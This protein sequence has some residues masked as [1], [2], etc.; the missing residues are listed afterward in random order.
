MAIAYLALGSN[1]NDRMAFLAQAESMINSHGGVS[2]VK[3]SSVYETEPWPKENHDGD[4]PHDEKGQTWYLNQ[5][6]Q[7]ETTLSPQELVKAAGDIE[8]QIGRTQSHKWG[9]REIDVDVLLYED[10]I[11]D[12]PEIEIPH[13][14]MRD[15]QFV[16]VPLVEIAPDLK[17][18]V[19]KNTF[20]HILD[21]VK[22]IDDHKI[23]PFL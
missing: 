7:V 3:T 17:D 13:R 23:I 11:I 15:R 6:I 2:I 9:P 4:H 1:V 5:V 16:L 10:Q 21:M 18:P 14:H 19:T 20:K 8:R 22:K 12:A